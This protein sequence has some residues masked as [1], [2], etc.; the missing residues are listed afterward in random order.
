MKTQIQKLNFPGHKQKL[1]RLLEVKH[2]D[3][4]EKQML[5]TELGQWRLG[6]FRIRPTTSTVHYS[7]IQALSL[8]GS[9]NLD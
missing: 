8:Q 7:L 1:G 5:A 9:L 3:L 2:I 6:N 4:N